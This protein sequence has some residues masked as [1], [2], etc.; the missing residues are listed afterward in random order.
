MRISRT[1]L[2]AIA[3][4]MTLIGSLFIGA[5]S[6]VAAPADKGT[7]TVWIQ[8]DAKSWPAAVDR[9]NKMFNSKYPNVKVDIQ[10][11]T[12]GDSLKK[13]DA[14]LVAGNA[15]DV[16]EFGNT[17]VLKYSAAGALRDLTPNKSE[18]AY[19]TNWL[20]GLEEAGSYNDKLYAVPYYAGSRAVMYRTDLFTSLKIKTPKSYDQFLA[21]ADKLMAANASNSK[22]SAVYMPGKYWYAAMGFVYD[23]KGAAGRYTKPFSFLS[24]DIESP[25]C[26]SQENDAGEKP[27]GHR[28][29]S[30]FKKVR[31]SSCHRLTLLPLLNECRTPVRPSAPET[32]LTAWS[33]LCRSSPH[34]SPLVLPI[35]PGA[36]KRS[37]GTPIP[38]CSSLSG[39][40]GRRCCKSTRPRKCATS[41]RSR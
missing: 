35:T 30:W 2:I 37:A 32:P 7:V 26:H 17:Q 4:S 25:R 34:P 9:A 18:F 27:P 10:Y 24:P 29:L 3:S 23:S 14:A 40:R 39:P 11:Q 36:T 28:A 33:T 8:G 12:W 31:S 1:K 15:P 16:F 13:L 6:T 19:S 20:K 5:S 21:A 38:N 41:V 22:F